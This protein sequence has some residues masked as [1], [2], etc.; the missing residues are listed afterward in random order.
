MADMDSTM[1]RRLFVGSVA[2]GVTA[3]MWADATNLATAS[4][5]KTMKTSSMSN[6][7]R[8]YK[9]LKWGMIRG[10]M[11][12][13]DKFKMLADLGY[14]GVELD[15]PG[16]VNKDEA[17]DASE[18]TGLP[19]DGVVDSTH[20]K[21]RLTDQDTATREQGLQDLLTAIRETH[22][23]QGHS[24]LLVP[25]HGNDG[26]KE[27]T[28]SRAVEQINKALPLAS[29]LGV[30]IL[31]ENVWN[32]MFYQHDGPEDQTADELAAFIDRINSPWVG[33]HFDI[34]NHQKYSKPAQWIRTLGKRIVK[35]D[36]K[37]WG[38]QA[39][40]AKIGE[41]DVDWADVRQALGEI[42]FTGWAAAEVKGGGRERL[43]EVAD[44][45]DKVLGL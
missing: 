45:M 1:G 33:V 2:A 40:W 17:R 43:K 32:A 28:W 10:N 13:L 36:V 42:G 12:T 21:I 34:G 31:I 9:T 35:L 23:V 19:I 27:E 24:V 14:D 18:K 7:A 26:T 6:G 41:G 4:T 20:W 38:K 22:H 29:K 44:N 25:G 39:G 30:S 16:G 3:P 5:T 11:S 37:D 8:I 15:S